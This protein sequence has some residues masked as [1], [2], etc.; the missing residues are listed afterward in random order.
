MT[1][2]GCDIS[3]ENVVHRLMGSPERRIKINL[4]SNAQGV[5]LVVCP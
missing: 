2:F 3:I 4:V 5:A 1:A